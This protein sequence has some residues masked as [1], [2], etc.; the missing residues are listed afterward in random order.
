MYRLAWFDL[1]V[2]LQKTLGIHETYNPQNN[3]A[4][5]TSYDFSYKKEEIKSLIDRK[6]DTNKITIFHATTRKETKGTDIIVP[7]VQEVVNILNQEN[8]GT[9]YEFIT[10]DTYEPLRKAKNSEGWVP[11]DKIME[12]KK[13]SHFYVDEYN[14]QVGY[15]GGSS[16]EALLTGN[17]TLATINNFT[18]EAQK[19]AHKNIPEVECPVIHLGSSQEE[20][21]QILLKTLRKP[22]EEL[23]QLA[24]QGLEWYFQTS[25]H[26]A[27]ATKFK[28]EVLI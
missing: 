13:M 7:I 11:N 24:Y 18:P 1:P 15:F 6:F 3:L 2:D 17:I 16:V 26:K 5:Y 8:A 4:I 20:F 22:K 28:K 25:D 10:P 9:Q 23:K 27:V 21:K 19:A 12:T 14:S